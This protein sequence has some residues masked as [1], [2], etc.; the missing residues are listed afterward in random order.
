MSKKILIKLNINSRC[1]VCIWLGWRG[2]RGEGRGERGEGEGR[3]RGRGRGRERERE[4]EW[5]REYSGI[6]IMITY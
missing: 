6:I 2:E 4:R 3:G 1:D 5:E